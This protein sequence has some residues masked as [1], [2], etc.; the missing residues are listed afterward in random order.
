MALAAVAFASGAAASDVASS[1]SGRVQTPDGAPVPGAVVTVAGA[2]RS[3]TTSDDA[4]RFSFTPLPAGIYSVQF[5]KAGFEGV[6]RTDVVVAAGAATALDVTLAVSSFSSLQTIGR[7]TTIVPGRSQINTTTAAV[8]VITAQDFA[9]QGSTQ[10][11]KV[12]E[13]T[14]G[15]SLTSNAA[16]GGSNHAS[17]GAPEYPQ[18]RGSLPYETESLIDGHPVSV[19]AIGT[20][21]PLLVLPALLQTVEVVKGP[22]AMPPEINYA[23]GGT[24]NYRTLEPTRLPQFSADIGADR[25]G[26]ADVALRATGSTADHRVDYAFAFATLGTP[27]PLQNYQVAGSQVFLAFGS[28]P[29]TINGLQLPGSPV[30]AVPAN[31]P[32]F[33]GGAGAARYAEPLYLCCTPVSTGYNARGELGKL[34]FNLSEQTAL[35]ISY[36]GGQSG[37]DFSGTILGTTTP[38]INFSTFKPPVGYTGSIPA[39]TPIPFDTQANTAY[40]EFVQQSLFQAELRSSIGATTLLARAYSGFGNTLAQEYTPGQTLSI[41]EDAWGGIG[42]CPAGTTA[43]GAACAGAGGAAVAPVPT[44][45]N[46]QPATFTTYSPA[47]YTLLEDHL[48]GYSLVA[49][50]PVGNAV[51]S[52][53]F[54]RSQ[55]DS[56]EF[57]LLAGRT[58]T[59]TLLP[60]GSSQQFTTGLARVQAALTPRLSATLSTYFTSYAS[61]YTGDGG[62]TW[63]DATHAD[64]LPRLAFSWRPASDFAW[65]LALGS[66]I[67]PPYISLLSSPGTTPVHDP[68]GAAQGYFINANSGQIAPEEAF[69]YDLGADWRLRPTLRFSSDLYYTNLRNMFLTE[70]SQQG[71]YTPSSGASAGVAEPLYVTQT[72]NLGNARYEGIEFLLQQAPLSGVGFKIQGSLQRAYAYGLSPSF[73]STTAG[74]NTTNLGVVPNIN[75][76]ASGSGFNA[77]SPGRIPYSQ[78]Y[79]EV[80]LRNRTGSLFLLGYAYFGPN[81]SFNQPAF[82]VFSASVRVPLWKDGWV[83]FSGDNLTNVYGQP[84]GA[85]LAGVPVPLINGKLGVVAGSNYGPTTLQITLHQAFR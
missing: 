1:L 17:L 10:V 22:G 3:R 29:W 30:F 28:P 66:S 38:L 62:V 20:F 39:G 33:A 85:L 45:F 49:D 24:V 47:T 74:P 25:Y 70:T 61:H 36:L 46:G 44:F 19:G 63:H 60:P 18:L 58:A 43:H 82:G 76:Q 64:T 21:S 56:D 7:T 68:A 83:Q 80:N 59:L 71:T 54:D 53:A 75:F 41:T 4:G 37:Q 79:A 57:A 13:E 27:G 65:R 81:N 55:H 9:D 15:V 52:L 14:P 34:R 78:G 72:G 12:L 31:T 16:G 50:R 69:G 40:W 2:V 23:V 8:A 11:T 32:Q 84:Y 73:Y 77:I 67:A 5:A 42:L 26:G 51:L 6:E 48:R 35:T